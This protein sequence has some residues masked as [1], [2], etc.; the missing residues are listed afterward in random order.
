MRIDLL[1]FVKASKVVLSKQIVL[2]LKEILNENDYRIVFFLFD[3][4]YSS[5]TVRTICP[6]PNF[7]QFNSKGGRGVVA[8]AY[9]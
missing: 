5:I 4:I 2:E 1:A 7:D 6:F 8:Y 9:F 3:C